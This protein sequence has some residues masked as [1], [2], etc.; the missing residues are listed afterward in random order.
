[1]TLGVLY[2]NFSINSIFMFK[3]FAPHEFFDKAINHL[4]GHDLDASH[5]GFA[6]RVPS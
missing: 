3:S 6:V 5:L 4:G 2:I 1:M